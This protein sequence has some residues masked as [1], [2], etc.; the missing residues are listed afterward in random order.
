MSKWQCC[1]V[2][3]DSDES[4]GSF[5]VQEPQA[6]SN[7]AND[8][9][10]EKTG[11]WQEPLIFTT[12]SDAS[13]ISKSLC[14]VFY[15]TSVNFG[16]SKVNQVNNSSG[17]GANSLQAGDKIIYYFNY[18]SENNHHRIEV[19]FIDVVTVDTGQVFLFIYLAFK[20]TVYKNGDMLDQWVSERGSSFPIFGLLGEQAIGGDVCIRDDGVIVHNFLGTLS[21]VK[22][23]PIKGGSNRFGIKVEKQESGDVSFQTD[24]VYA[25]RRRV[26]ASKDRDKV[27]TACCD[28]GSIPWYG[29]GRELLGQGNE[30]Q[31]TKKAPRN[32]QVEVSGT[33]G[34]VS[35]KT[36]N[37]TMNFSGFY[38]IPVQTYLSGFIFGSG[39][40]LT[41]VQGDDF[42]GFEV[43]DANGT[44]VGLPLQGQMSIGYG[45][46]GTTVS[47]VVILLEL[48][49]NI[50]DADFQVVIHVW[51]KTYPDLPYVT[52][53]ADGEDDDLRTYDKVEIPYLKSVSHNKNFGDENYYGMDVSGATVRISSV[54]VC[55]HISGKLL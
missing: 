42:L 44:Q 30:A 36:Y 5:A 54:G 38:F 27:C 31:I 51:R 20:L 45:Y 25:R 49:A 33:S 11:D 26:W 6:G 24:R 18:D 13:I 43:K 28:Y 46:S 40:D 37:G 48:P 22:T 15:D 35:G 39:W 32:F 34:G 53:P 52:D 23:E 19:E 41:S 4:V 9:I 16:I 29:L 17:A 8:T 14:D 47:L 55:P 12:D 3:F 50:S 1:C 21:T 10:W 2:V 7:A